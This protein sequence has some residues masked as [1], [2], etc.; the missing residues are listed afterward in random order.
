MRSVDASEFPDAIASNRH[1]LGTAAILTMLFVGSLRLFEFLW[2]RDAL[3]D[4]TKQ[5]GGWMGAII[6]VACSAVI[7]ELL[8]GFGWNIFARVPWQ[9]I[10][11]RPSWRGIGFVAC[12]NV[13]V[14][15]PAYR[16]SAALPALILGVLP[17]TLGFVTGF[18]LFVLWGLFFLLE[19]FGDVAMLFATR[20]VPSRAWVLDHP[21]KL[22]CRMVA[23]GRAA[24][25]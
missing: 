8:H 11:F 21:N 12:L 25:P 14:P 15:A 17:I 6:V 19:C 23:D 9:S 24:A 5:P 16:A 13:P 7:H 1:L 4:I 20:K 3:A 22:G 10:S 2:D 18:G